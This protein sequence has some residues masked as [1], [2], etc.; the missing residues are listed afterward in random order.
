MT[1]VIVIKTSMLLAT[2]TICSLIVSAA[3]ANK[4][5]PEQ[6]PWDMTMEIIKVKGAR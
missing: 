4:K 6:R 5:L 2:L 1:H 3:G